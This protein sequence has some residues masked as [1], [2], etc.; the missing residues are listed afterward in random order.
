MVREDKDFVVYDAKSGEDI[1]RPVLTQIIVEQ[2][3]KGGN[4][5]PTNFLRQLI[6]M[7]GNSVQALV[8]QYL[9]TAMNA[10]ARN[11]EQ[12]ARQMQEQFGGMFPFEQLEEMNRHNMQMFQ[13]AMRMFTP[14]QQ[15]GSGSANGAA[16][17][18]GKAEAGRSE[19][20]KDESID[21]LQR[22]LEELQRQVAALGGKK[23]D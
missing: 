17:E 18:P 3:S 23:P 15:P 20:D 10:F 12:L 1:T 8:P 21:T 5:L 9:E 4:M 22:Q 7:Y 14:F 11:Q 13:N 19:A 2:E 16:G 6:G